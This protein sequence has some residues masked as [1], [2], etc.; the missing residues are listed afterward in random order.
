MAEIKKV[1]VSFSAADMEQAIESLQKIPAIESSVEKAS[2]DV[3]EVKSLSFV[4]TEWTE[5]KY[6]SY[7]TGKAET[8]SQSKVKASDF[9]E[10]AFKS[11]FVSNYNS[12]KFSDYRGI[13]FYDKN[14]KFVS[15]VQYTNNEPLDIEAPANAYFMRVTAYDNVPEIKV[16]QSNNTIYNQFDEL[17]D[18]I[19]A[20]TSDIDDLF[21]GN[22]IV[23]KN[24]TTFTDGKY[25][26]Y[27]GS[28][29]D[30][31]NTSVTSY[32]NCKGYDSITLSDFNNYSG[33]DKR[34]LFFFDSDKQNI[35]G[36]A[37]DGMIDQTFDI[38]D[39]AC[40]VRMTVATAKKELFSAMLASSGSIVN[41]QGIVSDIDKKQS[42]VNYQY[43][44]FRPICIGDSLTSGASYTEEWGEQSPAGSSI[45]ENYPR[46]LGRMLNCT[47]VNAGVSGWS[48]SDWYSK[49]SGMAKHDLS[50]FDSAVIWL[51]TN[52]GCTSMPTDDEISS[53]TP[54]SSPTASTA[55]QALYL[56]SIINKLR[57]SYSD[58]LVILCTVFASKSNVAT[59]NSVIAKIAEKYN[60][61]VLDM[62]DLGQK[63]KPELHA[64]INNVHFGKAGN[65]YIAN[66]IANFIKEKF[67]ENPLL[68]EFGYTARTN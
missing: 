40:F 44:I 50:T 31:S 26:T 55:N 9:I 27:S 57:E 67:N 19:T 60:C 34:G 46:I 37:Y 64:G 53:F 65:I 1:K 15:G 18:R 23:T 56:I 10:I 7:K 20:A 29:Y 49:S 22:K 58:M 63:A 48:A 2:T 13:A 45:D 4:D 16:S 51:G 62:S 38:P 17:S 12:E 8:I 59:N 28:I 3:E 66:R 6:I 42:M 5:Q 25:I 41:L 47:A 54:E 30:L 61:Y 24:D 33:K 32:I 36:V 52:Y 35:S 68:C 43:A 14:K 11:V 39:G 21:T